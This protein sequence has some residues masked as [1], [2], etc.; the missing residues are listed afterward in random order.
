MTHQFVKESSP[1][2]DDPFGYL[3]AP[4]AEHPESDE[5]SPTYMRSSAISKEIVVDESETELDRRLFL[6]KLAA[7]NYGCNTTRHFEMMR[8]KFGDDTSD[9]ENE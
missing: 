4:D 1:Y 7:K 5:G 3:W 6:K 9:S 8:L 2:Q